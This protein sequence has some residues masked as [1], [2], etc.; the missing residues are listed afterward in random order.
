MSGGPLR[1]KRANGGRGD[2]AVAGDGDI[3]RIMQEKYAGLYQRLMAAARAMG[4]QALAAEAEDCLQDAFLLLYCQWAQHQDKENLAGWVYITAL[5]NLQNRRRVLLSRSRTVVASLDQE[6]V[7]AQAAR[8]LEQM[9]QWE[10]AQWE[11]KQ[12]MLSAV[13]QWVGEADY[14]FLLRYYGGPGAVEQMAREG[15][16]SPGSLWKRKQRI[17]ER[18][19][20]RMGWLTLLLLAGGALPAAALAGEAGPGGTSGPE[21]PEGARE[22]TLSKR[23][24]AVVAEFLNRLPAHAFTDRDL[25]LLGLCYRTLDPQYGKDPVDVEAALEAYRRRVAQ[26]EAQEAERAPAK[27]RGPARRV[28][29]R[30]AVALI[31]AACLVLAGAVCYGLGWTPWRIFTWQDDEHYNYTIYS[32]LDSATDLYTPF[33]PTGLDEELDRLLQEYEIY[34]PLPTWIPEGYS[35]PQFDIVDTDS[36]IWFGVCFSKDDVTLTIDVI[37]YRSEGEYRIDAYM[38]K[39]D[40]HYEEYAIGENK[41]II[42]SNMG[43]LQGLW[44]VEPYECIITG[45]IEPDEMRHIFESIV[46]R[47]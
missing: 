2:R 19:K 36:Q 25:A 39:D 23:G 1:G 22:E 16:V 5:H 3:G 29:R 37:E 38:E 32:G 42:L 4:P 13:R 28:S 21:A 40:E 17:M 31:L 27:A 7:Q 6:A 33:Q 46:E 43:R 41:F 12:E 8:V 10:A 24:A 11:N 30:A 20:R 47:S 9:E 35:D 44:L 34:L 14:A 18:I 15:Q 45:D 26:Y